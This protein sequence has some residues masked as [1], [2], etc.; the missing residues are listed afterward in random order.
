MDIYPTYSEFA[1]HAKQGNVIPISCEFP[2]DLETPVSV[3][4]KLAHRE[5][6]AFL[7]E[8]VELGERLGRFSFI[9]TNP[10]A[11]LEYKGNRCRLTKKGQTTV[12]RQG[13]SLLETM[14]EIMTHYRLVPDKSLPSFV[15]GFVGYIGYELVQQFDDIKLKSK[16]G[17]PFPDSVFF[18]SRN[19]V[20]FDHIKHHL[21]LIHLAIVD[22]LPKN[23]YQKGLRELRLLANKLKKPLPPQKSNNLSTAK[24]VLFS[25]NMTKPKFE[26]MV[27]RAKKYIRSGD[28]IQVVLSQRFD[29]G[30]VANDFAI[31]RTLRSLNPSPYMFYFRHKNI[32]LIGSSPE[33]MTK[34][35]GRIAEVR[36]IAGTRPRG[37]NEREDAQYEQALRHSPKEM[38]EHLMLVDLGRNDLGR[39]SEAASVKVENFA[40]V[41]RYSHVMHLVSDVKATMKNGKTAFDLMRATF[42]AGT[43]SGAPKIRAMQIIDEL[44]PERRGPYAGSVGYF[45][46][47]GDM[48]VC[49]TI[50]T[51][52][53]YKGH[54]Y[55]QAGAGIVY[56]SRPDKEYY[57]TL[58]KAKALRLAVEKSRKMAAL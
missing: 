22:G 52:M 54:A 1:R 18:F 24:E 31:Y 15:G 4:L 7:L 37:A 25:S 44:E 6:E 8:S 21:K 38:A 35:T 46:L 40:H 2:A 27:E 26:A 34:K 48:D 36:P 17:L 45:S 30:H 55:V 9:G 53:V 14:E 32:S 11:I 3:F 16:K 41:E 57:E 56:D 5:P 47:T 43:L 51:I 58:N 13:D 39:V 29:L 50:R 10:E 42:P 23:A 20:A 28:V 33:L 19:L 12:L 49:I